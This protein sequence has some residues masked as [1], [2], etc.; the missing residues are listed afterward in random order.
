MSVLRMNNKNN[1]LQRGLGMRLWCSIDGYAEVGIN[2]NLITSMGEN[3]THNGV[4]NNYYGDALALKGLFRLKTKAFT[5][6]RGTN[7]L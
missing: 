4:H 6:V 2:I 5:C 1:T 3:I 7:P